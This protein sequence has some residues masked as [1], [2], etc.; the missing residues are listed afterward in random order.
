VRSAVPPTGVDLIRLR[1]DT[2]WGHHR[3]GAPRSGRDLG[4][5]AIDVAILAGSD[6]SVG[7]RH[8]DSDIWTG[9]P[10]HLAPLDRNS[11]IRR[12]VAP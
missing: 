3:F 8:G 12:P 9:K 11:D 1:V 2:L 4:K 6:I 10:R 5:R 7:P